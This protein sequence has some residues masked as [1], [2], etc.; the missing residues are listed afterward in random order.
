LLLSR[1]SATAPRGHEFD[2]KAQTKRQGSEKALPR[3]SG[4]CRAGLPGWHPHPS[5]RDDQTVWT[6]PVCHP[7]P[8]PGENRCG[9]MRCILPP[10]AALPRR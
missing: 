4:S 3:L 2:S 5:P 6:N 8:A 10:P 9:W 7:R 1:K